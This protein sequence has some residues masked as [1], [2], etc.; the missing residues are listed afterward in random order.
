MLGLPSNAAR[1][2]ERMERARTVLTAAGRGA[3]YDPSLLLA[4]SQR[5]GSFSV[6]FSDSSRRIDSFTQ[7]GLDN[8]GEHLLVPFHHLQQSNLT[9]QSKFDRM[10]F[11]I[12]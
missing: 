6:V 12:I 2:V 4:L 9:S 10:Y 11:L 1:V 7:G 3:A 5:E 8:L